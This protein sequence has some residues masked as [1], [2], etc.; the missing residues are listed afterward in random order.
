MLALQADGELMNKER[1]DR[2]F[3]T[4]LQPARERLQAFSPE[5]ICRRSGAVYDPGE[6]GFHLE[7]LGED[8]FISYPDFS[9]RGHVEKWQQLTLLQYLYTADGQELSGE[10]I[11]L[12]MMRGGLSRGESFH[13]E[14][15][16][17]SARSFSRVSAAEFLAAC[18]T[19]GGQE[20]FG[21]ADA[22]AVIFYAPR[23]PLCFNF[24][25]ADEEFP[26]SCRALADAGADHYLGVEAAGGAA[27]AILERI[28]DG[29]R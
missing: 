3:Y 25:E 10:W 24:W 13:K 21:K 14:M 27:M 17:L 5:D 16:A 20:I 19:L 7:S 29:L 1:E 8:I 15:E 18:R 9:V 28:R 22:S 12:S 26:A 2:Q 11:D 4:M 6:K 23:F